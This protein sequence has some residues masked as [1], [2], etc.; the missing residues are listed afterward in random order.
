MS[1]ILYSNGCARCETLK[2]MLNDSGIPYTENN[3]VDEMLRLGF[4]KTPMLGVDG[5][6]LDYQSAKKWIEDQTKGENE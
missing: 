5:Y 1:I 3:S 4:T 2:M 6:Y